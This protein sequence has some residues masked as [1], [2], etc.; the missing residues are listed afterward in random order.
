MG[1]DKALHN[2]MVGSFGRNSVGMQSTSISGLN[3]YPIRNKV[4]PLP[5]GSSVIIMNLTSGRWIFSLRN[6][7][8]SVL[9][10]AGS[11]FEIQQWL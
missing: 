6:G 7:A 10:S 9:P 3:I 8:I 11:S 4:L 2:A 5:D 1:L